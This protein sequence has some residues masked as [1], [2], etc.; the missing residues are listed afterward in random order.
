MSLLHFYVAEQTR[1]GFCARKGRL[2]G[3]ARMRRSYVGKGDVLDVALHSSSQCITVPRL[4][5]S[6]KLP[7]ESS[8]D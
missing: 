5:W 4:I 3:E 6:K 1:S 7:E 2:G 8:V